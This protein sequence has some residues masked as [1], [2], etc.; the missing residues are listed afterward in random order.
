MIQ[1]EV[2]LAPEAQT[3]LLQLYDWIAEQ[4]TPQVALNYLNRIGDYI[5]GFDTASERGTQRD[6]IRPGLRI[7]GF[8]RRVTIAFY[9][10]DRRVVILRVFYGG[11]NWTEK[12]SDPT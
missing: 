2:E 6:D 5:R 3:D 4:A 7:I 9:V 1:R 11:Q 8:E 10:T 12:L